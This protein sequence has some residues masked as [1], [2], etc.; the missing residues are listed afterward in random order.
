M[1]RMGKKWRQRHPVAAVLLPDGYWSQGPYS[2]FHRPS[3]L[4]GPLTRTLAASHS[5][6]LQAW[7]E[8]PAED[9]GA[10]PKGRRADSVAPAG[11]PSLCTKRRLSVAEK[12]PSKL[13]SELDVGCFA[14]SQTLEFSSPLDCWFAHF[15]PCLAACLTT[16]VWPQG[17]KE[18]LL[19][20]LLSFS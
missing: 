10:G 16:A 17:P 12:Y 9:S 20:K 8:A 18:G 5:E 3:K 14:V 2:S 7:A 6:V 11:R 4:P 13:S 19:Q 15:S 1:G